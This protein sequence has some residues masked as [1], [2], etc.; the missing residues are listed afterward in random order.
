M[1]KR[2]LKVKVEQS[3]LIMLNE[4]AECGD[5]EPKKAERSTKVVKEWRVD[6]SY[7]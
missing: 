3:D 2:Y 6:S 5:G 7:S 4:D 1:E